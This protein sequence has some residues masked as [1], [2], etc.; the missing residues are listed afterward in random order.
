MSIFAVLLRQGQE[1]TDD[2]IE[3][4]SSQ[5]FYKVNDKTYLIVSD[6]LTSDI[7][8]ALGM[9]DKV[10]VEG[11]VLRLTS[12]RAGWFSPSVWEW[13]NKIESQTNG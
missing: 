5:K 6:G 12:A 10:D 7:S 2:Q 9:N 3:R 8:E 1:L 13:F 11:V 4:V